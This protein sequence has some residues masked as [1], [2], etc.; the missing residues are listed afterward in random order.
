M[1]QLALVVDIEGVQKADLMSELLNA[2]YDIYSDAAFDYDRPVFVEGGY[3]PALFKLI[4]KVQH[5]VKNI[6]KRK[7]KMTRIRADE[8]L[9]N[10]KPFINYKREEKANSGNAI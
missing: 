3:L 4:E 2:I 1:T 9:L 8:A 10:L 5:K 7:S 6:D